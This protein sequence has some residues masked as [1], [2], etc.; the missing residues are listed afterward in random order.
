MLTIIE[1]D[2]MVQG[3][4]E[5]INIVITTSPMTRQSAL[6]LS[7]AIET[8]YHRQIKDEFKDRSRWTKSVDK[9]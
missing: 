3:D 4:A 2:W 6:A 8:V 7:S 1:S 5:T 9:P